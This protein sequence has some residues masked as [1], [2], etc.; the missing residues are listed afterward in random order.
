MEFINL[1][2]DVEELVWAVAETHVGLEFLRS[3]DEFLKAY[4]ET[5]ALRIMW[6]LGGFGTQR[7]DL[8]HW[9]RSALVEVTYVLLFPCCK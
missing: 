1:C 7:I 3:S 2:S 5:T 4:V 9:R 8:Q 6:A